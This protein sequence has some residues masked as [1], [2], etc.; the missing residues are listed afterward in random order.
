M[1]IRGSV[2]GKIEGGSLLV[3]TINSG[4]WDYLQ[5]TRTYY[6]RI[7]QQFSRAAVFGHALPV[8]TRITTST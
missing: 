1:V 8:F 6:S 7:P 3:S 2:P 4:T 5:T